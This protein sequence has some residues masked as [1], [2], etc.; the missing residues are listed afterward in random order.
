MN[1]PPFPPTELPPEIVW[2]YAPP[3]FGGPIL[4]PPLGLN[5]VFVRMDRTAVAK[6]ATGGD[7]SDRVVICPLNPLHDWPEGQH[8]TTEFD[9]IAQEFPVG[10]HLCQV[11]MFVII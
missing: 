2:M 1:T 11:S 6:A 5:G 4:C 3:L 8:P 7:V 9:S 10:Q